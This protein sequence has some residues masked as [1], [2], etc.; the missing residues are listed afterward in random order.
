[1]LRFLSAKT[2]YDENLINEIEK[3]SLLDNNRIG[4]NYYMDYSFVAKEFE[5]NFKESKHS[6]F[7]DIGCGPGGIH[8]F[9]ED[10]YDIDIYG[11]D[12]KKWEGGDYVDEV[13]NFLDKKFEKKFDGIISISAFEHQPYKDHKACVKKCKEILADN[14]FL[15]ITTTGDL[16]N[17]TY[18]NQYICGINKLQDIYGEEVNNASDFEYER[19]VY[20]ST[21]KVYEAY[22]ERF[23]LKRFFKKMYLSVGY[24]SN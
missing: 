18:G 2:D 24:S 16:E 9:L 8:G 17:R 6:R 23:G 19:K 22:K 11:L 13:K 21:P 10:K 20:K 3:F 14:G 7:L 5:R 4:W 15:L 12:L 1:M